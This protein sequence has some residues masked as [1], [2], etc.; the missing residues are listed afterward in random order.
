[1]N[2]KNLIWKKS[3]KLLAIFMVAGMTA[4]CV[5][6]A[7]EAFADTEKNNAYSE[8]GVASIT[9]DNFSVECGTKLTETAIIEKAGAKAYD[10][11]GELEL[12]KVH[13]STVNTSIPGSYRVLLESES[14]LKQSVDVTVE[15][16]AQA[17]IVAN[18][19]KVNCDEELTEKILVEKAGARAYDK[20]GELELIRVHTS[21]VNTSV[22]GSYRVLFESESGLKQLVDVTVEK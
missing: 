2:K 11:N 3:A 20:D 1:M 9:G 12:I 13:T 4:S 16:A 10:K 21:T 15:K 22:P 18:D 6:S 8:K 14:G 5:L 19:F 17:V 7:D